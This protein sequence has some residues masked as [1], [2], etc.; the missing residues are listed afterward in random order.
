M[1]VPLSAAKVKR[2]VEAVLA[3][4]VC[5]DSQEAWLAMPTGRSVHFTATGFSGPCP[6]ST[7]TRSVSRPKQH[8]S[9]MTMS[10]SGQQ[11]RHLQIALEVAPMVPI[12]VPHF[13]QLKLIG[14]LR[15]IRS[16]CHLAQK[17]RL[18]FQD[19]PPR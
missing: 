18:V 16:S 1:L 9:S 17:V 2:R 3:K 11:H 4:G 12:V 7:C 6:S 10:Q 19:T 15:A 13:N 8:C 5:V 14:G